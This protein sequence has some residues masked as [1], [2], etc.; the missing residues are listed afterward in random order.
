MATAF[1]TAYKQNLEKMT[2]ARDYA[3]Q[4]RDS[5]ASQADPG[6]ASRPTQDSAK[7]VK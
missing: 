5:Q 2:I 6:K 4:Q 7:K 3:K 1:Q